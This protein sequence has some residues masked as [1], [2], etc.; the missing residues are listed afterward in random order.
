[1]I[2]LSP[3]FK[4]LYRQPYLLLTLTVLF[5]S[6]NW[7]LGRALRLD[8]PPLALAFWRWVLATLILAPFAF[9]SLK[10]DWSIIKNNWRIILFLAFSGVAVFNSLVYS[11]LQSTE[12][13][14]AFLIQATMPTMI[15]LLSFMIFRDRLNPWQALGVL[16]ALIGSI[17]IIARGDIK[18]L[19]TL[20]INKGSLLIFIAVL[21]YA[22]YSVFLRQRPKMKGLSFLLITFILG[23]IMQLPFYL[24][25][26]L[27]VRQIHVDRVTVLAILYVAIFPS[28]LSY[29]FYNRGLELAGANKGGLFF[30]LMPIFGSILA[31]LLLDERFL[32]YHYL[33]MLLIIVGIG[34]NLWQ[35]RAS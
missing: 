34:L 26:H 1:M 28:I 8:I 5:W 10:K 22:L 7:I 33:G 24:W 9:S 11:G 3:I 29:L 15:V 18:V 6:G 35:K 13:I 14:N 17:S 12:A 31:F 21:C 27:Y 32:W 2:P 23:V 20:D 4:S 25:E 19:L 16:L 30:Y